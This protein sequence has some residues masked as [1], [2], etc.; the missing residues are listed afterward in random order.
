MAMTTE[1]GFKE[2]PAT[3]EKNSQPTR[4]FERICESERTRREIWFAIELC[5]YQTKRAA[6][7]THARGTVMLLRSHGAST[8]AISAAMVGDG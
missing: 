8:V 6:R 1:Q 2:Y 5:D 4:T 7:R 3:D